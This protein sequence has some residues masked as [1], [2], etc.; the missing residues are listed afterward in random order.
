MRD[1]NV[2]IIALV[3]ETD[4]LTGASPTATSPVAGG[5]RSFPEARGERVAL[6]AGLTA[7][8]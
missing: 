4:A 6:S 8:R 5:A 7:R 2:E 3:D 1:E